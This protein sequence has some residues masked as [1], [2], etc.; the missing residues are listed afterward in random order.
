[1]PTHR[2][3]A[4]PFEDRVSPEDRD[5]CVLSLLI[6]V[7]PWTVEELGCELDTQSGAEDAVGRLSR[8]GL[9]HRLGPLVF[10]TRAGRRAEE[11][12]AGT[13]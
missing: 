3:A 8:A 2:I 6:D 13:I 7:S 4:E 10:P 1:M 12:E 11:I 9:L 5:K